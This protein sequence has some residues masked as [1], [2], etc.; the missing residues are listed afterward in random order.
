MRV[1]AILGFTSVVGLEAGTE[2]R[3]ISAKLRFLW[4]PPLL[5]R[6]IVKYRPTFKTFEILIAISKGK[7]SV[8]LHMLG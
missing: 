6:W 5:S 8:H 2:S 1:Q 7:P 3:T 4:D